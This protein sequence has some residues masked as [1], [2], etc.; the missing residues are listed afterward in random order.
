MQKQG[1]GHEKGAR[2][3]F[4]NPAQDRKTIQKP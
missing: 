2:T 4:Q 3:H 1:T